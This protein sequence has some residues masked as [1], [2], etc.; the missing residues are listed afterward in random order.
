MRHSFQ[1]Q[2]TFVPSNDRAY[3]LGGREEGE[4]KTE[5]DRRR[6]RKREIEIVV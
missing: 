1:S 6:E 3:Y 2:L 4:G 5:R